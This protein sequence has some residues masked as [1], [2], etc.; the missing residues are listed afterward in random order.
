MA[1]VMVE[2]VRT[3]KD[4]DQEQFLELL[5]GH[6]ALMQEGVKS[7]KLLLA[8]PKVSSPGGYVI[9]NVKNIEE[10]EAFFEKDPFK[11]AGVQQYNFTEFRIH[12]VQE[13]LLAYR[14]K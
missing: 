8:G 12:D 2:G 3:D 7:G 11:L 6:E 5:K 14:S 13:C 4:L 9:L 1:Y 10:A